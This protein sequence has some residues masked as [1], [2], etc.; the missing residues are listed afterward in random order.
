MIKRTK[1]K[2]RELPNY[3]R[4]EEIMNMVTHIV[5][6][7]LAIIMLALCMIFSI[8]KGDMWT[9][10]STT[11][12][13][14]TMILLYT[15]SSTYHGLKKSTG[16]KVM[17][18]IDHC[19][20]F[21]LIAGTYTPILLAGIRVHYPVTAWVI[22][23][24]QWGITALGATFNAIDLKKYSKLSMAAYIAMGWCII[25]ALKKTIEVMTITGFL[26]LLAGGIMY[27][28]G[29]ILYAIG[30]KKK[31]IHSVFHIFVVLASISQFLAIFIYIVLR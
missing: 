6:G 21:F 12:Y 31:Y 1:L 9:I 13:C 26:Y 2:D 22:F 25:V 4:G 23:A 8:I 7:G 19:T 5:G 20:I 15:V 16:K 30:K 24:I 29:A 27:T 14:I 10:I 3:T 28:I 17:Q 11:I 18:I